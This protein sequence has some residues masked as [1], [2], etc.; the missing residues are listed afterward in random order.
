MTALAWQSPVGGRGLLFN[1]SLAGGSSLDAGAN[2]RGALLGLDLRHTQAD[3]IRATLEGIALNLRLVLDVLRGL[4]PVGGEM[5]VVGGAAAAS[6]GRKIFADAWEIDILKTNVGQEAGSLARWPWP[7][8]RRDCGTISAAS[9]PFTELQDRAAACPEHV[10]IYRRLLPSSVR[11][12]WTN[13]GSA[14]CWPAWGKG[15][16]SA[17]QLESRSPF[18]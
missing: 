5:V 1:P 17:W 7:R 3:V 4:G 8:L 13:P 10:R 14:T 9:T 12:P 6:S 11:P 16:K 15:R 18:C 2:I